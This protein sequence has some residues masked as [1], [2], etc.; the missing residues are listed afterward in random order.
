MAD[1]VLV[2][3]SAAADL[4]PEREILG[5]AVTEVPVSL[6]WRVVQS[7]PGDEAADLDAAAHADVHM[8]L[9]GSDIRAP[10]GREWIA[11]RR[12]G[13]QPVPFLKQRVLQTPAAQSYQRYIEVQVAW[14]P[15][16]SGAG[17]RRQVLELL[18]DHILAR[19]QYYALSPPEVTRLRGWRAELERPGRSVD[20]AT[21]GGAAAS[22][23]VLS[24][25]RYVPS[26][27]VLIQPPAEEGSKSLG[28][29]PPD[30]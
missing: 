17:L 5:R 12:A 16:R 1:E 8:L 14:R 11:A 24:P 29:E 19:A 28:N 18:A 4:Q 20:E 7:P 25:Q 21:Q 30:R 6:G 22:G 13:R 10:I 15:F 3:I 2:Y 27:G 26:D 9:L 23:I